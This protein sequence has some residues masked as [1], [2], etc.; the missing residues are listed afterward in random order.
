MGWVVAWLL[1]KRGRGTERSAPYSVVQINPH[2]LP[3]GASEDIPSF[4]SFIHGPE[5]LPFFFAC[6]LTS[7]LLSLKTVTSM[8]V[9]VSFR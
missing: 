4:P 8:I 1:A 6:L 9:T 7:C 3:F 5:Y 2:Q